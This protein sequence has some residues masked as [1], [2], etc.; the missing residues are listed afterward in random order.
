MSEGRFRSQIG[1]LERPFERERSGHDLP[2]NGFQRRGRQGVPR[3]TLKLGI[4]LAFTVG[5]INFPARFGLDLSDGKGY[6]RALIEKLDDLVVEL[7][8]FLT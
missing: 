6:L 4:D 8:N 2:V 7:I 1:D 3:Q 5:S